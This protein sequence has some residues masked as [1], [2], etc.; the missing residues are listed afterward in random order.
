M[1]RAHHLKVSHRMLSDLDAAYSRVLRDRW[2]AATGFPR[3]GDGCGAQVD[4]VARRHDI[5]R[6][7]YTSCVETSR[8]ITLVIS[9]LTFL[10]LV[11]LAFACVFYTREHACKI[12]AA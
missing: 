6:L 5:T 10:R 2:L 9:F 8:Q 3:L 7:C 11:G 4:A 1:P 12:R